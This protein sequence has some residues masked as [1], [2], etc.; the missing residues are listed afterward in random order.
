[1]FEQCDLDSF[2]MIES[3]VKQMKFQQCN[4]D[5]S[6]LTKTNCQKIDFSTCHFDTIDFMQEHI[7]LC[8][9]N[10]YQIIYLSKKFLNID[11][12]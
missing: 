9:F 4:L 10:Q 11:L 2:D 12:A 7:S 5:G 6:N 3:D 1:M 8:K